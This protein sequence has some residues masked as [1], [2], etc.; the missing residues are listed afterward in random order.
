MTDFCGIYNLKNLVNKPTCYK[1]TDKPSCIDLILTN[2]QKSFQEINPQL[3]C[4]LCRRNVCI[5]FCTKTL[6]KIGSSIEN[7]QL[8]DLIT[9]NHALI[10]H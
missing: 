2:R 9:I 7:F 10:T 8:W 1:K 5:L 3:P 6:Q 4:K